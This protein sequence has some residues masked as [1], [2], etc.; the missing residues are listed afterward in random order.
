MCFFLY[1]VLKKMLKTVQLLNLLYAIHTLAMVR[2]SED[3]YIKI[4]V[5]VCT[6]QGDRLG[7]VFL[8]CVF[9]A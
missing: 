7:H 1:N 3:K 9:F 5:I 6:G 8:Y 4:K 2:G